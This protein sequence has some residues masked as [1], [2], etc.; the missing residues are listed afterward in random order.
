ME[1]AACGITTV[2]LVCKHKW[3]LSRLEA[4]EGATAAF[5]PYVP[6][7]ASGNAGRQQG[8][9]FFEASLGKP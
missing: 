8:M 4:A 9:L 2:L 5:S 6:V 1:R 7:P 3:S